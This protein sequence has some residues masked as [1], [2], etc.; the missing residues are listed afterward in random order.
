MLYTRFSVA[1]RTIFTELNGSSGL[2]EDDDGDDGSCWD[3]QMPHYNSIYPSH[4]QSE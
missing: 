4:S 3:L 1:M 2:H